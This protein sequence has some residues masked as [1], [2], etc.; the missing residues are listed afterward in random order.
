MK[1]TNRRAARVAALV[2]AAALL[3]GCQKKAAVEEEKE[4]LFAVSAY[5]VTEGSLD[6]YLEFGG[7]I[8]SSSTVNVLPDTS[9]KLSRKLVSVGDYV[10]KDQIVAYL[11][12]SRP[13]MTYS[14]SPVRAPSAG[15]VISFPLSIGGTASP[16]SPI[17][18]LS[19]V[20]KLEIQTN[21]AERFV[22]RVRNNQSASI[23]LDA[24]PGE[25]FDA[26]VFEIS[27]VLDT[28]TR[29]I[30]V[31]L[32][33]TSS[34]ARIRAGMYARVRLI[35]ERLSD[36]IVLPYSALVERDN[37]MY[38]FVVS[39]TGGTSGT[40]KMQEVA[41]GIH[42]DDKVEIVSGIRVG[43]EIVERGQAALNDGAKVNVTSAR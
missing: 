36:A 1:L 9:G 38:V 34:D 27:P 43:D 4:T 2:A 42:V 18:Q 40:V 39:R 25:K 10:H 8:V 23:T 12:P 15:T 13:G 22:S 41:P 17:V 33:I 26:Q 5:T 37:K 20:D 35:T 29:T 30:K 11:D 16:Q 3:G 6:D 7:D 24:F 14:E 19:S 31:K 21:I 32:R 28:S